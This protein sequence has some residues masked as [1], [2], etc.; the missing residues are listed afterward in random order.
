MRFLR[1]ISGLPKHLLPIG[2][3]TIVSR[4]ASEMALCCDELICIVPPNFQSNFEN[5][6]QDKGLSVHIVPKM[7][8]G[9]K[10]DFTAASQSA[11]FDNILLTVGDIIFPD[12]EITAF[13]YRTNSARNKL[14]LAFD[15]KRLRVLKFPTIIDYRMVLARMPVEILKNLIDVNPEAPIDVVRNIFRLLLKKQI[16]FALVNTMFNVNTI[17]AYHEARAYFD[18]KQLRQN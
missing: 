10:G 8:Q 3:T 15:R 2:D 11:E 12:N 18:V 7:I 13:K 9:F 5:E 16:T 4:T 17:Q 1:E 14:V 6:F